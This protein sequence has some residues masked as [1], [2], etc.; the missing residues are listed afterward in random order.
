MKA[1]PGGQIDL[2]EVIGRDQLIEI[3]WETI[4]QQSVVMTAERRIGKTTIIKKMVEQP[5]PHWKP[6]FHDLEKCHTAA[7]FAMTVY[8]DVDRFL[9]AKKKSARRT[10]EFLKA[11]GGIEIAGAFKLPEKG[12]RHWKDVLIRSIEDLMK[13]LDEGDDRLIFFWDELPF[14]LANIR[15]GES[16]KTAM[17]VLDVLRS[18]RQTHRQLRMVITGSIG[19]HHVLTSL[20]EK[21]YGNSPTNDMASIDVPPL[22]KSD[23]MELASKLIKGEKLP[24]ADAEKV[25]GIIATESD[26][27]PFYIHHI[28][29]ALKLRAVAVSPEEISTTVSRQMVDVNDPWELCHYRERIPIYYGEDREAVLLLL[30]ELAVRDTPGP[31]TEL[32]A[33]LKNAGSMDDRERLLRLLTLME[34]DHYLVRDTGGKYSFRFP[35]IR[36][37]WKLNRGF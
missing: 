14:M 8:R 27:F 15:D 7:E 24:L 28:V 18:L 2:K 31:L 20:K 13:E 26:C 35:L 37:W 3:I 19:L 11:I 5:N 4:E 36:R 34:R 23:A 33:I 22:A 10:V 21:N 29:K 6:V 17:E 16:E 9:T 1:N 30:D 25:P 32:L 12:E